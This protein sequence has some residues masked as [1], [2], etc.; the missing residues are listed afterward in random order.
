MPSHLQG[1]LLLDYSR[2]TVRASVALS[3]LIFAGCSL[4][5]QGLSA[6]STTQAEQEILQ[7]ESQLAEALN[8]LDDAAL[9]VLWDDHLV[10][11]GSNGHSSTKA[12]R[13]KGVRDA[14]AS[15][16]SRVTS[17]ND[18]VRVQLFGTAA[19]TYVVSSWHGMDG[20]SPQ[21]YRATH[22]WARKNGKWKLV[23][24]HVS[25]VAP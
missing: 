11:I 25:K 10:F 24:A 16:A 6:E 8:A 23:S 13:L 7:A 19:V 17:T 22:V 18:D 9:D 21:Q 5:D 14:K 15:A 4:H 3:V 2:L 1:R 12:Q 20:A